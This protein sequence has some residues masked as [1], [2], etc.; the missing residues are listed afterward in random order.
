MR[1]FLLLH[2]DKWVF[3]TKSK[4]LAKHYLGHVNCAPTCN[5]GHCSLKTP[6]KGLRKDFFICVLYET[7]AFIMQKLSYPTTQ[8]MIII[9][10]IKWISTYQ[11]P[12]AY[13]KLEKQTVFTQEHLKYLAKPL[14]MAFFRNYTKRSTR[15]SFWVN[16]FNYERTSL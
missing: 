13:T 7:C 10:S 6:G 11:V 5:T 9:S 12:M 4:K 3:K 16:T 15:L 14:P 1:K 8:D 2:P